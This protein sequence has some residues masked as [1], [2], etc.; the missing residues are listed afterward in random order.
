MKYS[1]IGLLFSTGILFTLNGFAAPA[2]PQL[3]LSTDGP[4]A[5]ASWT[6]SPGAAG[7]TLFYAPKPFSGEDSV[8]S[9]EMGGRQSFSVELWDGAS[10]YVAVKAHD[11]TGYSQ[12]SNI[13]DFTV[14]PA[15]DVENDWLVNSNNERSAFIFESIVDTAG[16][17]VNVES[18]TSS[19]DSVTVR[20]SGIPN[21]QMV[22]DEALLDKLNQQPVGDFIN[23]PNVSVGDVIEFGQNIGYVQSPVAQNCASTGGEG[24]W[25]PGPD[26][27]QDVNKSKTFT[28][29]PSPAEGA[30]YTS[31]GAIG[32][33]VNGTSV[34]NWSDAQIDNNI[35]HRMAPVFEEYDVD[36]CGG[37]AARGDYHHHY[38]TQCLADI[39]G[40]EGN[41]HSPVYG[42]ADDGYPIYG[43]WYADGVL[44]VS[45]WVVRDYSDAL[46]GCSDGQR[47]CVMAD[48][49]DPGK[50]TVP[51]STA[52]YDL[53]YEKDIV[54]LFRNGAIVV[55]AGAYYE[56]MYWDAS[57]AAQG[58]KYLDEHNGHD[59]DGLGYH[60]HIT[61][62][63]NGDGSL[64]PA[65]PYI[66][67]P[68]FY[69]TTP[70]CN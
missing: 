48:E 38:Y 43:P 29:S 47:S 17:L 10:F 64:K 37:H 8:R 16:V 2:A 41:G 51:A 67:G 49:F 7:Y 34:Y 44:A 28:A 23:G 55:N 63:Q 11:H 50:G 66:I 61:V 39:V 69:G 54:P 22:I 56:D 70:N 30:C 25:P 52:G 65:F 57:L 53:G 42:Y 31:T 21:Y 24:Y 33:M 19:G 59:H 18:V 20:T 62:T 60:Y 4:W 1:S 40:D 58:G 15:A 5:T 12:Y 6:A 32:Y 45:S 13:T 68:T 14:L 26:C 27:P 35:W 36:V 46:V 3:A 9:I